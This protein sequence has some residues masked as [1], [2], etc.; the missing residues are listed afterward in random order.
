MAGHSEDRATRVAKWRG[1]YWQ[2][3]KQ[4]KRDTDQISVAADHLRLA[5][6]RSRITDEQ[7]KSIIATAVADLAG[8]AEELLSRFERK[9]R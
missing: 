3:L 1:W 4:I 9:G 7:R 8:P 6:N 2:A 5:I